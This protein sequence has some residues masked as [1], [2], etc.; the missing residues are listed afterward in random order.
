MSLLIFSTGT[1][2]TATAIAW[3][4]YHLARDPTLQAECAAE[5]ALFDIEAA[6][7]EEMLAKLPTLRSLYWEV[8]HFY[9][10]INR[11]RHAN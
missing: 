3:M 10:H 2:T 11:T 8:N 1:D 4:L 7:E 6:G 5:A 9:L